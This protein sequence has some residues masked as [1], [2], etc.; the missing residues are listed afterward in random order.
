MKL[1]TFGLWHLG[2]VTAACLASVGYFVTGL[3]FDSDVT[4]RLSEGYA[5]VFE[6]GLDELIQQ[7]LN[8]GTLRFT[9]DPLEAVTGAEVVWVT[10]DTPVDDEDRA[11]VELVVSRIESLFPHLSDGTLVVV[12]SQ[13]PI[14]SVSQLE[15]SY[16]K[17]HPERNVGFAALPENLRLGEALRRFLEPDRVV[18]G[19]RSEEERKRVQ[20]LL[21]PITTKIE[22]MSVESAE[23]TKH[24]LNAFLAVSVVFANEIA[25]LCEEAGADA[26][27]VERGLKTD[28][29]IGPRAYV[30]PGQAFAGGTLARDIEYLTQLSV[31]M[32]RTA[33]MLGMVAASNNG[34]KDWTKA[35]LRAALPRFPDVTVALFG[36]TYK[37]GTNT[38]RRS[39]SI[40]LATWLSDQGATVKAHDPAVTRLPPELD[41]RLSL[42]STAADTLVGADALVIG[43]DWPEFRQLGADLIVSAMLRPLVIDPNRLLGSLSSDPRIDYVAVGV[44]R[45]RHSRELLH[46]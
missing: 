43:T 40:E 14:G 46:G 11:D 33:P 29:R 17:L 10:Y 41:G 21:E 32:Q 7:G 45:S 35:A 16:R 42:C 24:A 31:R 19:V 6:P 26:K 18:A 12:S 22:W 37:P 23:M 3:D 39:A 38:L 4:A 28:I 5:P 25:A 9:S 13:L 34:H 15:T 20:R 1:C 36:L 2:S 30:G 27:E 8:D 44:R